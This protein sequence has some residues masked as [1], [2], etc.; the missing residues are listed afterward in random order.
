[1]TQQPHDNLMAYYQSYLDR[2]WESYRYYKDEQNKLLYWLGTVFVALIAA[3]GVFGAL[4]NPT[5]SFA[6]SFAHV[7]LFHLVFLIVWLFYLYKKLNSEMYQQLGERTEDYIKSNFPEL[8]GREVPLF[9]RSKKDYIGESNWC[10]RGISRWAN[11]L[12]VVLYVSVVVSPVFRVNIT[13]WSFEI[14][15]TSLAAVAIFLVLTG[16]GWILYKWEKKEVDK[17]I[18]AEWE[19]LPKA[20]HGGWLPASMDAGSAVGAS[21]AAPGKTEKGQTQW[22]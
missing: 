8:Q 3:T 16:I 22:R 1:M 15:W 5:Q 14:Y 6:F 20:A 17:N 18:A 11:L 19:K 13:S 9:F 2:C 7:L 12:M 10:G 4:R 21:D